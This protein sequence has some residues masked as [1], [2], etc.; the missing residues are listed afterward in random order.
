MAPPEVDQALERELRL[1]AMAVE[2]PVL[3][4]VLTELGWV[5]RVEDGKMIFTASA[6]AGTAYGAVMAP[7][8]DAAQTYGRYDVR[9]RY[10]QTSITGF[11]SVWLLWPD[12]NDWGEGEI[13]FG[14]YREET[15]GMV[16]AAVHQAC[17]VVPC[18]FSSDEVAVDPAAVKVRAIPRWIESA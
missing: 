13:D 3:E 8:I 1:A 16:S 14:E 7:T 12:S 11:K 5:V 18:T 6:D 15:S 2:L 9:Y 4:A 17:G 10:L